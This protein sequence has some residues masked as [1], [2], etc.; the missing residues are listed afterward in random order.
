MHAGG[1]REMIRMSS[2][3][4]QTH[5]KAWS[6]EEL[7]HKR[8]IALG[9]A[10]DASSCSSYSSALNS[11]LYFCEVHQFSIDP[12]PHTL[13]LYVVW[14]AHSIEPR[15]VNNYLSGICNTLAPFY[16]DVRSNRRSD[17]VTKTMKGCKRLWSKPTKRKSPLSLSH[18][19]L[20]V[21]QYPAIT[22]SHDDA[23]FIAMVLTGLH[24]LLRLGEMT[25]AEASSLRNP[26]KW[27]T[28]ASVEWIPEGFSFWLECHKTDRS[29]EGA[30]IVITHKEHPNPV[31]YFRQYLT[32]RDFLHPFNPYLWIRQDGSVPTRSW[33]LDRL[34]SILKDNMFAGQS[35]RSGGATMLAEQGVSFDLIRKTG[36]WS[37]Q[38]FEMYIR[39]NPVLLQVYL[40][41]AQA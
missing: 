9:M 40:S 23:L 5:R 14:M 29:F 18:I 28:R 33:F 13:S 37:S 38:A 20:I 10:L 2:R 32:S 11:Y 35:L 39:K 21:D 26:R 17:L 4:R 19:K 27:S 12:T 30:R 1:R 41:R 8:A 22:R 31:Q 3:A 16:P 6:I 34:Q 15:S 36:R 25:A 7:V 24:G